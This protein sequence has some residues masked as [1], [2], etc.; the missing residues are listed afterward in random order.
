MS[1]QDFVTL[2]QARPFR[3]FRLRTAR[4]AIEVDYP[5]QATLT[6]DEVVLV[7]GAAGFLD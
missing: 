5:L 7:A 2:W 3:A 1:I 6:P 4:G